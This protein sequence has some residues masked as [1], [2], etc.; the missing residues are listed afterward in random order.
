M[1]VDGGELETLLARYAAART[2]QQLDASARAY[3]QAG[4][5][6]SASWPKIRLALAGNYSTQFIA[7]GF[8]VALAARRLSAELYESPYNQWRAELLDAASPLY[9]FSPTHVV[10][11]LTSIELAYGALRSPG[12]VV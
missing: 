4:A 12:V 10:L 9:G 6:K 5:P 3:E 8:P 2:L 7:R 1:S 11:A